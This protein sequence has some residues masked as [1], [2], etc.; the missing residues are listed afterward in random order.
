MTLSEFPLAK[1]ADGIASL[2]IAT[3]D[4]PYLG[5]ASVAALAGAVAR[6][7]AD[8]SIRVLIVEGGERHF[9]AGAARDALLEQR[10]ERRVQTYVAELPRLLLSV[11]VPTIAAMAGHAIGGGLLMGLWCD[12]VLLSL[13]SLYGA[14][15]M[16]LGFT[17]GMGSTVALDEAFGAPLAREL[18]FTGRL[19]TGREIQ[20]RGVPLSGQVLPRAGLRTQALD[21]AQQLA[22]TPARSLRELKRTLAARRRAVLDGAL[23]DERRMHD[24]VFDDRAVFAAIEAHYGSAWTDQQQEGTA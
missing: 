4:A 15:F 8:D 5:P 17:P 23:A 10:P 1:L 6:V 18:L 9:C 2:R 19:L 11:P 22:D 12:L 13:E 16:A 24:S 3:D 20:Q 14:N 7:Q 21:L